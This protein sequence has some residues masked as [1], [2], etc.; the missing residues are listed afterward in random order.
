MHS[1][2]S[3]RIPRG[4]PHMYNTI[5]EKCFD[6]MP[7]RVHSCARAAHSCCR[8]IVSFASWPKRR[9]W[10]LLSRS[11]ETLLKRFSPGFEVWRLRDA[12][13]TL[14]DGIAKLRAHPNG[15]GCT[16]FRRG[17]RKLPVEGVV[18]DA[19]QFFESVRASDADAAAAL[20]RRAAHSGA[21]DRV[22]VSRSMRRRAFLGGRLDNPRHDLKT[23]AFMELALCLAAFARMT[24]VSVGDVVA[25]FTGVPIGGFMRK[26]RC[27]L[28]LCRWE[29]EWDED[30]AHLQAQ[31]FV[32][33][34]WR[35][36]DA[37]ACSRYVDDMIML[38]RVL[39][40]TCLED[41]LK[42][43]H[44]VPFELS[45]RSRRLKWL[46]LTVDLDS[47]MID[48]FPKA[49]STA[50]AWASSPSALRAHVLSRVARW[51]EVG[52]CLDQVI[53][54]SARLVA[55]LKARG[56][57]PHHFRH[58]WFSA[59]GCQA[60]MEMDVARLSLRVAAGLPL[61]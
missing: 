24:F 42:C 17:S 18:A 21:P 59:R 47:L 30:D 45:P 6:G 41:A 11:Y 1:W 25:E 51:R 23:F 52:M 57:A 22:T 32:P 38:S 44:D 15:S 56:W 12:A 29:T 33:P 40:R 34:G 53:H 13:P 28:I 10:Q 43:M 26:V 58:V 55:D 60:S 20:F 35:W 46:D 4:C 37:A 9:N 8:K 27:S 48:L 19:G 7:P 49:F 14:R 61:Q 5:K 39:C 16:C 54:H 31:C 50:P 36:S 3:V 2:G